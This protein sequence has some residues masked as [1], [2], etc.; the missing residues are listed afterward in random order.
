MANLWQGE[1][2][3]LRAIEPENWPSFRRDGVQFTEDA[4]LYDDRVQAPNS[5]E[6]V[7]TRLTQWAETTQGNDNRSLAIIDTNNELT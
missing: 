1:R 5:E 6:Q 2:V 7:R 4:R 3:R